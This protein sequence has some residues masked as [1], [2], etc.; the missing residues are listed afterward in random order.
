MFRAPGFY[1]RETPPSKPACHGFTDRQISCIDSYGSTCP[2]IPLLLI[3]CGAPFT[4]WFGLTEQNTR[5][6]RPSCRDPCPSPS[7]PPA[8]E[9]KPTCRLS[10]NVLPFG[11]IKLT[12]N[13]KSQALRPQRPGF[14]GSA[15]FC[16]ATLLADEQGQS[17]QVDP[18]CALAFRI[19]AYKGLGSRS[20]DLGFGS[21]VLGFEITAQQTWK[22]DGI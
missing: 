22:M 8:R 17:R 5:A 1:I 6:P 12:P 14:R 18:L 16:N 15:D 9:T 3:S 21:S 4:R 19:W 20:S 13:S 2:M 7:S 11:V 10:P